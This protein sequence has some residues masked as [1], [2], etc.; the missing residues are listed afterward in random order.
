MC[1]ATKE[2]DQSRHATVVYAIYRMHGIEGAH[3][4]WSF[5]ACEQDIQKSGLLHQEKAVQ[6]TYALQ[7]LV[8]H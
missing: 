7:L 6:V 2:V 3:H 4:T 1:A 8:G 5:A